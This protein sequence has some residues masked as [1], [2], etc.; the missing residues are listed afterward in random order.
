M[1]PIKNVLR[2]DSKRHCSMPLFSLYLVLVMHISVLP[3][4][5]TT[6]SIVRAQMVHVST[7]LNRSQHGS[8]R[9]TRQ[10]SLWYIGSLDWLDW[11]R[12]PSICKLLNE[13]GVPFASFFCSL[14]LD[15]RNSKRLVT[16]LSHDLSEMYNSYAAS[17]LSILETNP[18]VV[19]A[20]L[21]I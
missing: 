13:A 9:L 14:Q 16:T 21:R 12:P 15:S 3:S 5:L 4:I 20:G 1:F 19:H 18:K 10:K 8:T 17:V 7:S 2:Y 11:G 6:L